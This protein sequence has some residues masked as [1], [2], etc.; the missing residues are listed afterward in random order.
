MC[1]RI[2]YLEAK[3]IIRFAPEQTPTRIFRRE[4]DGA[5]RAMRVAYTPIIITPRVA[6]LPAV[7][8]GGAF[9]NLAGFEIDW[10][11]PEMGSSDFDGHLVWLTD[12]QPRRQ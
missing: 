5:E 4:T 8:T 11:L 6:Q 9:E 12:R 2:P 7:T 10:R 1:V 3:P